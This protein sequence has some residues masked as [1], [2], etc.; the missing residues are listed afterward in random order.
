MADDGNSQK[1]FSSAKA[2]LKERK[3]VDVVVIATLLKLLFEVT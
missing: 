3:K 1:D 2:K